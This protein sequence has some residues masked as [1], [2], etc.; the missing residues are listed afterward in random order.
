MGY[1]LGGRLEESEV[2]KNQQERERERRGEG[3]RY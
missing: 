1:T 2:N 3:G